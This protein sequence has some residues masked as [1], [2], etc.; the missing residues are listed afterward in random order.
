MPARLFAAPISPLPLLAL[1]LAG[2]L[3]NS[4]NPK[5]AALDASVADGGVS[6]PSLDG[7]APDSDDAAGGT[8]LARLSGI[9][10]YD[11]TGPALLD[12]GFAPCAGSAPAPQS[13]TVENIGNVSVHYA[14]S[15]SATD[16]FQISGATSGD[17]APG[18]SATVTVA[19]SAVPASASAGQVDQA[20]LT[21]MTNSPELT[22]L[23]VT[24]QRT[25]Q[26]GTLSLS[27]ATAA[28]GDVPVTGSSPLALALKNTG[29]APV[30]IALGTPGDRQFA[31]AWG[32]P[33]A[34]SLSL[35]AG[36]SAPGLG[37]TFSPTKAGASS[38]SAAL[39]VSGAVC[40]ASVSSIPLTGT[41]VVGVVAVSPGTLD[42]GSVNCGS[43]GTAQTVTIANSGTEAFSFTAVLLAGA[44]S[45]FTLSPA[46]GSVAPGKSA[47]LI[48]TPT[49][50][51]QVASV[52]ANAFGD[53]LR[54]TSDA[55]GDVNHD[56][57]LT[58]TAQG[59]VLTL[60]ATSLPFGNVNVGES[61]PMTFTIGNSGNLPA[62]ITLGA[63][64]APF[65]VTPTAATVLSP[66]ATPFSGTATFSPAAT[67]MASGSF[68][69]HTGATDVICSAPLPA[70]VGLTGTGVNGVLS[71]GASVLP[72]GSI[73]CGLRGAPQS[74]TI[75]NSGTA[76][77][78]WAGAL[79][80][81]ASSP[82]AL[83]LS[84]ET[85][86]PGDVSTVTVTPAAIPASSAITSNLYGDTLT[87]TPKGIAGGAP[88]TVT[89]TETAKGAIFVV[90][91]TAPVAFG[92]DPE[93]TPVTGTLT[94]QNQGN[95]AATL[96]ASLSGGT[97]SAFGLNAPG[98]TMVPMG[99]SF[100]PAPTFDPK[101]LGAL[102][103]SVTLAQGTSDVLCQP[104][105]TI[106]VTG[107]GTNGALAIGSPSVSIAAQ[108][109]GAAA[110]TKSLLLSNT[111][112]APLTF[113]AS[114]SG[115]NGFKVSPAS[116]TIAATTGTQTLTIT[117]P[118]F[119]TTYNSIAAVTDTLQITTD[120]YGD[121]THDVPL[122]S[123]P[124]GAI[125]TWGETSVSLPS[126][127]ANKGTSTANFTVKNAG[128]LAPTVNFALSGTGGTDFGFTP[129]NGSVPIGSTLTATAS[130]TP[131]TA[132]TESNSFGISVPAGTALCAALPA[133]IGIT[134]TGEA[135]TFGYAWKGA[136]F[137]VACNATPQTYPL[138][139]T[140]TGGQAP[141]DF[142]A[143]IGGGYSVS[144]ASGTVAPNT[145]VTLTVKGPSVGD[146][147]IN[148]AYDTTL[149]LTTDIP[150]DSPH[151]IAVNG[152][153]EGGV[154]SF[155]LG[156]VSAIT[157]SFDSVATTTGLL[158]NSGNLA[159]A[160]TYTVIPS[161]SNPDT[162]H[163][164]TVTVPSSFPPGANTITYG[165]NSTN[166]SSNVPY[167]YDVYFA[168]SNGTADVC[169][170]PVLQTVTFYFEPIQ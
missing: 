22:S 77:F 50:I 26:G 4:S 138:T 158:T 11:G 80:K 167:A 91:S 20:M 38:S 41:G 103:T 93:G 85:L 65:Q 78:S 49:A 166:A 148:V 42:F 23:G 162:T 66:G 106:S 144:P 150:G 132:V 130:F 63:P 62:T 34:G 32:G 90:T 156:A 110:Q 120:A 96:T 57:A 31:L 108:T 7:A 30:S 101:T 17:V 121:T 54:I 1:T 64:L 126:V 27:P 160:S 14:L 35:A 16:V 135:G 51:P 36:A 71:V 136:T 153:S 72:F 133:P 161:A 40:G 114:I 45:P 18:M 163:P 99:G 165:W 43:T 76:S 70:T 48:V 84:G 147:A 117:G 119:G 124:S 149:V 68:A 61:L 155:K 74:F 44:A 2:C 152:T 9:P 56:V 127:Q 75:T 28:F 29:N 12:F 10:N 60:S 157:S 19:E 104:L 81:G 37:A 55:V 52:A 151:D 59:A 111:G 98:P 164:L 25:A 145:S 129:V 87:I 24:L 154:Y 142:T 112:S 143:S 115:M 33:D 88:Q 8:P 168:A 73:G 95:A 67:G 139:L 3:S 113:A 5:G 92:A 13:F 58:Q 46:S 79:G 169:T 141:Y 128:N 89:L 131:K 137:G 123:T 97:T 47:S 94:I 134:G 86:A 6:W 39:S 53:T 107:T 116:G 122:S 82:Y 146:V 109:C 170:S 69:I 118:T 21:V 102:S 83:S 140:N 125:L 159:G 100:S 105:P 15:L